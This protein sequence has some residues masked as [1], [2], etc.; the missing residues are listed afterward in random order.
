MPTTYL[1]AIHRDRSS[2]Y[3]DPATLLDGVY[4]AQ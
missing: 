3:S 2:A 1:E 4:E